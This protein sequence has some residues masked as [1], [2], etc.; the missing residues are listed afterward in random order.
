[1]EDHNFLLVFEFSS[2]AKGTQITNNCIMHWLSKA[3]HW[4]RLANYQNNSEKN[5][6]YKGGDGIITS[7]G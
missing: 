5:L 6:S 4:K 2:S 7:L 3:V 1:L